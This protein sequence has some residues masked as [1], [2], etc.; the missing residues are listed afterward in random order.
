MVATN[1]ERVAEWRNG[2]HTDGTGKRHT[3]DE[4]NYE[5]LENTIRLFPYLD[6][7]PLRKALRAKQRALI[8]AIIEFLRY[9]EARESKK[10]ARKESKKARRR[11]RLARA[12]HEALQRFVDA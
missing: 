6:T 3:L 4:M 2:F 10:D 8:P 11:A 1:E 9:R 5:H 7:S 12:A